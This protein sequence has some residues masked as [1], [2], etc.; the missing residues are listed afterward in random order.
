[1][2]HTDSDKHWLY[3][4]NDD[5]VGCYT[6]V[7]MQQD[8]TAQIVN[9]A[10]GAGIGYGYGCVDVHHMI[11]LFMHALGFNHLHQATNRDDYVEIIWD[12]IR[13][14]YNHQ[15]NKIGSDIISKD[16]VEYDFKS[17]MHLSGNAFSK[18]G[19]DTIIPLA[20]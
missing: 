15:F 10:T 12:N 19:E 20:S 13:P 16:V 9:L 8:S 3:I 18:N 7:G 17:I 1:M 5:D 4:T 11:H 2:P 6:A 14:A